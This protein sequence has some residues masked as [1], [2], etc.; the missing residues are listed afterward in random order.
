MSTFA[1][2]CET[3]WRMQPDNT[4]SQQN[5][6]LG[7]KLDTF[8]FSTHGGIHGNETIESVVWAFDGTGLE[9]FDNTL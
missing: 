2:T 8:C 3:L 1:Q 9:F 4:E 5:L 7:S 6:E